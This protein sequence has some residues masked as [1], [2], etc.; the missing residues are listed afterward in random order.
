MADGWRMLESGD[1][2][3]LNQLHGQ[4]A[5]Q[6]REAVLGLVDAQEAAGF[7]PEKLRTAVFKSAFHSYLAGYHEQGALL[8]AIGWDVD[9]DPAMS[10]VARSL[11]PHAASHN[12]AIQSE[13]SAICDQSKVIYITGCARS[14]TTLTIRCV[15]GTARDAH[16]FWREAWIS[17][18]RDASD[19]SSIV[20][21]RFGI[22]H[23]FFDLVP[24]SAHVLHV[25][26]HPADTC[27]SRMPG[28]D[29]FYVSPERWL[30]EHAAAKRLFAAH[31]A[32]R[33]MVMRY[34]DLLS[35]PDAVQTAM[36][37]KWGVEFDLPFSRYHERNDRDT[38]VD[39]EGQL[40]VWPPINPGAAFRHRKTDEDA[41]RV[42]TFT[43]AL[44]PAYAEFCT[45]FG[46]DTHDRASTR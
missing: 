19:A 17:A 20:L 43:A 12:P 33:L 14:G 27:T 35:D 1:A 45:M 28:R 32:D 13:I 44:G 37:D 11:V 5:T 8:Y 25:V 38:S 39:R 42:A 9:P 15:G 26:R 24:A 29:G 36:A 4:S 40:Y 34:E 23:H 30:A 31:P 16:V 21:K 2:D 10:G 18:I 46:Y 3:F 22:D 41:E 7:P 6:A